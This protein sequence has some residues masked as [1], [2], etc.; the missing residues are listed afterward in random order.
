MVD[1]AVLPGFLAAVAVILIAPGPDMAFMVASGLEGGASAAVRAAVGITAGVTVYVILSAVG[2]GTL[3]GA[4]PAALTGVRLGGAAYLCHLGVGAW[5]RAALQTID[6]DGE[7][8]T[9]FFR[10]GFVVNITNPKIAVFF[11][12]FLP[13]FVAADRGNVVLQLVVLGLIL[14]SLGLAVDLAVGVMAGTVRDV[15][16][17]RPRLHTGLARAAATTYLL[18]AAALVVE[19]LRA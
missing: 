16:L 6:V 11:A 19:A 18:V 15:V 1:P 7:P 13:Q 9:S 17:A 5:R 3:L 10:R 14:Q 12:A 4:S 8:G 2:I